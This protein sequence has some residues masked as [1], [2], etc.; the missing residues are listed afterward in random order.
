MLQ[1]W[2]NTSMVTESTR[3][4][5]SSVTIWTT[6]APPADQASAVVLGVRISMVARLDGR[7]MAVR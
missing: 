7:F 5:R 2:R 3:N 6:V 1:P 4:G